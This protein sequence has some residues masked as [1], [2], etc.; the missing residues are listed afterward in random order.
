MHTDLAGVKYFATNTA[1][2]VVD[3][4]MRIVGGQGLYSSNPMQRYYRD[5][6]AG[7]HNPPGDDITVSMFARQALEQHGK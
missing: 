1:I 5:V 2:Q 4:A 3:E 7:L 6:R